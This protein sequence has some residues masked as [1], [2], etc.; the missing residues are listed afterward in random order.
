[1]ILTLRRRGLRL[2]VA[3]TVVLALAGGIAYAAIPDSGGTIHSCFKP[4]DSKKPGGAAISVIDSE[5][6]GMCKEGEAELTF[7]QQ[8]P[9]GPQG[10]QGPQGPQGEPGPRGSARAYGEITPWGMAYWRRNLNIASVDHPQTG[11]YCVYVDDSIDMAE[12]V[13]L[14][15]PQGGTGDRLYLTVFVGCGATGRGIQVNVFDAANELE[16][17]GFYLSVP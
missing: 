8:G 13:A 3:S 6:G 7:N 12:S 10:E 4:A 9:A 16:D 14:A 11:V 2:L 17:G 1:M 15:T 5:N